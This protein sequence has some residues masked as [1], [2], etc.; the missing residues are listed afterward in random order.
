[1]AQETCTRPACTHRWMRGL[2][3][4]LRSAQF[5]DSQS[6]H[7]LVTGCPARTTT[8]IVHLLLL[9]LLLRLLLQMEPLVVPV[10]VPACEPGQDLDSGAG[11]RDLPF[12]ACRTCPADQLG[13]WVDARTS[14]YTN[15]TAKAFANEASAAGP[16]TCKTC[17]A[18]AKCAGGA[19][20][21]PQAGY[22]W[23]N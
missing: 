21:V 6:L 20:I 1:M 12:T 7:V 11:M 13:L 19:A 9:R 2:D 5:D 23:V 14:Y 22:W 8:T 3:P 10:E 17:P 4:Q 18:N 15:D 16:A